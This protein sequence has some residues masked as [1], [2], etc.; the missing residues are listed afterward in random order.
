MTMPLIEYGRTGRTL[1]FPVLDVHAHVGSFANVISP[2]LERQIGEMDRVGIRVQMVSSIEAIYGDICR[3]ND[4]AAEAAMRYPGR[5]F[6]Y[7]QVSPCY[8]ELIRTELERCFR[9]PV[10]KGVKVYQVG[11]RY[12]DPL[13]TPAWEFARERGVPVLAH[14]WGGEVTGFDK[15]AERFPEVSF[16]AG[17]SGSGFAYRPYVEMARRL[18]NFFLD[19]TY[20]REHTNMIEHFVESVGAGQIVWGSDAPTFSI[21]HQIGK[22]LYAR[23]PDDAKRAILGGNAFKLFK[24]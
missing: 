9:N 4:Q 21:S 6:A 12:D 3:G 8:P 17:H 5:F 20:S 14:T 16:L 24:L 11:V 18:P 22:V 13:F 7:C 23:I 2:S 19:L 10:F 15:V 1:D